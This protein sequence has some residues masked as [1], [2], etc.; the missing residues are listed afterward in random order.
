MFGFNFSRVI[1]IKNRNLPRVKL[2][3]LARRQ[4][5][6]S[7]ATDYAVEMFFIE[8]HQEVDMSNVSLLGLR[9]QRLFWQSEKALT[10]LLN[11]LRRGYSEPG[12]YAPL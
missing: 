1:N 9:C 5:D 11:C 2:T 10:Y 3:E 12:M 4:V 6:A 8:Q 7:I